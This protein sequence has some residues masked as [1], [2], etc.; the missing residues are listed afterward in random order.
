[1]TKR[2]SHSILLALMAAAKAAASASFL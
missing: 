2:T 1:M